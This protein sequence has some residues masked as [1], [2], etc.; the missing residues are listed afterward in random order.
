MSEE[1]V[2][3]TV[4]NKESVVVGDPSTRWGAATFRIKTLGEHDLLP[5]QDWDSYLYMYGEFIVQFWE[6]W[7][8]EYESKKGLPDE[9]LLEVMCDDFVEQGGQ[10]VP[11]EFWMWLNWGRN[12]STSAMLKKFYPQGHMPREWLGVFPVLERNEK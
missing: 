11:P 9:G 1:D 4:G 6:K 5:Q 3:I 8:K 10:P 12:L 7:E 2:T